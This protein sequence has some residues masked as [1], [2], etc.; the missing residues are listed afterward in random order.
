MKMPLLLSVLMSTF[1]SGLCMAAEPTVC[2][3][4]C[5]EEKRACRADAQR[6]TKLDDSPLF[7]N[8]PSGQRD[9]RAL[10]QYQGTPQDAKTRAASEF[11]KR[12]LEREQ[13][14]DS[15]AMVCTRACT[16]PAPASVV[17]TPKTQH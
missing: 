14:C 17:L 12:K 1:L 11:N 13:G 4:I 15:K 16:T 8:G 3:S 2:K 10:G 7:D 6:L 9:A 5:A